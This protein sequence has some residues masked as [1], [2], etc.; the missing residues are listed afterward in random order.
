MPDG[1]NLDHIEE[2]IKKE[3]DEI[4]LRG[5]GSIESDHQR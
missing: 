4:D 3:D 2:E 5:S 1:D